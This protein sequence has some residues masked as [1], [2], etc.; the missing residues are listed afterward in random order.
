M[1]RPYSTD[2]RERALL[3]CEDEGSRRHAQ[4]ARR[5]RVGERTLQRWL[6]AARGEG[7]RG[8]KVPARSRGLVGGAVAALARL[9]D[10]QNDATLAEYAERLAARTGVRRS[11]AAV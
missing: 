3:A 6:Q 2:L 10:E 11:L 8:P 7:R 5:F 9:V 4:V 1:P